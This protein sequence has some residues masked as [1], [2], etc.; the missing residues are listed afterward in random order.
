[1]NIDEIKDKPNITLGF[2]KECIESHN[3]KM[4]EILEKELQ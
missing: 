1:M 4:L 3:K 2:Y